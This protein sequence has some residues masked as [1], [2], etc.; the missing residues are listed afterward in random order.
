MTDLTPSQKVFFDLYKL[1]HLEP[2]RKTRAGAV[3]FLEYLDR[4]TRDWLYLRAFQAAQ[5]GDWEFV[6]SNAAM[7]SI[8]RLVTNL[9][10]VNF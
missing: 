10:Y 1:A 2:A 9:I 8:T 7:A 6:G 4:T 3:M 5:N